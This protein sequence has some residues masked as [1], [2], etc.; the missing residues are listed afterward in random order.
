MKLKMKLT[1]SDYEVAIGSAF[2]VKRDFSG[3][4]IQT[5]KVEVTLHEAKNS[6]G[7]EFDVFLFAT[8]SPPFR[9][10]CSTV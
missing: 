10:I 9:K 6:S 5:D 3:L 4:E 1:A 8:G 7:E 2:D